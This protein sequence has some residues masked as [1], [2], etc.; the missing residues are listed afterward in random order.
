MQTPFAFTG[1]L[2]FRYVLLCALAFMGAAA[3]SA[4]TIEIA[5]YVRD[6]AVGDPL[7]HAVVTI[8][9]LK[10]SIRVDEQGRFAFNVPP[11]EYELS[12]F[13]E[14]Y[15]TSGRF[16]IDAAGGAPASPAVIGLNPRV[17]GIGE[18]SVRSRP[19][20]KMSS[21]TGRIAQR[22]QAAGFTDGISSE[23]MSVLG[24][25]DAGS[26]LKA[27]AGTSL[28]GGKYVYVRGLGERYSST[29]VNGIQMPSPEPNRRVIPMDLFPASLLENIDVVKTFTADQPGDFSGGSVL[30]VTKDFPDDFVFSI[31][32]S[33][34][35]N[36][37]TTGK[38]AL[39][40]DGGGLDFLGFDDGTREVPDLILSE[41]SGN[42]IRKRGRF[43]PLGF[44]DDEIQA[45]GR[46][47]NNVWSPQT[48]RAPVNQS[49]KMTLGNSTQMFGKPF[50]YIGVL[51]Y[52][53]DWNTRETE[54]STF[55]LT[56]NDEGETELTPTTDYDT[57]QSTNN[58]ALSAALNASLRLSNS[59]RLSIKTLYT[60]S[61]DKEARSWQ[62]YN[63]DRSTD[64]R[65]GRILFIERQLISSQLSGEHR[66]AGLRNS[67]F[68]WRAALS[69]AARDEPDSRET[70]YE[71]RGDDFY[72]RD[73]TQSGSRFFFDLTDNEASGRIDWTTPISPA[74]GS[75]VKLGAFVRDRRRAFDAR[76]FRFEPFSNIEDAVNLSAPPEELFAEENI[77]PG[78]FE[79][80]EST[81]ATDNY[82]A[83]QRSMAGYVQAELTTGGALQ[84]IIGARL[85]SSDQVVTT[86]DPFS[87]DAAPI[88]ADLKAVD[89]L[90]SLNLRYSF[91][92][93][94]KMRAA[95]SRTLTRPDLREMA[96]FEYTDFVGG[97][98]ELGNPELGR[99]LIQNYDI[100]FE[101]YPREG[102]IM[103]LNGFYKQ[104]NDPIEE[105]IQPS[106]EVITTYANA[107]GASHFGVEIEWR[108]R[109]D[110]AAKA[111][112]PFLLN[113]NLTLLKSQVELPDIGIQTSSDRA[114][115]GQSPYLLN[116]ALVYDNPDANLSG[117]M[118]IHSFGQRI[119]SVGNHGLPD[120]YEDGRTELSLSVDKQLTPSVQ[121]SLSGK[122]L[123]NPET[124]LTQG[125]KT[126]VRYRAGR[127]FSAGVKY[128]L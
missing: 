128:N 46:S 42:A 76:R 57:A 15:E 3:A 6:A 63:A 19:L 111:L 41:A 61:T 58:A 9:P 69:Q 106:A 5:G 24:A 35:S 90:P 85:E 44:E 96:P 25:S 50:G 120:V 93:R 88:V 62:G 60:R 53:N 8:H 94:L 70:L 10:Q 32:A 118:N 51:T 20:P 102:E 99:T 122:N 2:A 59:A 126:Y 92:E 108:Q 49:Y 72:F 27:V 98:K 123:L 28:V 47:F 73:I 104:F 12:A 14:G 66:F 74:G 1:R 43:T 105:I 79:L 36:T 86:F 11:G 45:F 18:I 87:T 84:T 91:T 80:R 119:A 29:L 7:P 40:Y 82:E 95:A 114:L 34:S 107:L 4:Q 33:L 121:I 117:T 124:L 68:V 16:S 30:V 31:S 100:G 81:R 38:D 67:E 77:A 65:S 22:Q 37:A 64:L 116:I 17:Y 103:A 115:Q 52:G 97:S 113:A 21:E 125:E 75:K 39:T 112:A 55:R 71:F 26:A 54:R 78:L 56:T 83:T 23:W 109:L 13:A 110:K 89:L 127:S 101:Y 48:V